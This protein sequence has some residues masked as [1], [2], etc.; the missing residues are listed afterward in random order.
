MDSPL[1]PPEMN[2]APL[3]LCSE[4][5]ETHGKNPDLQDIKIMN[6]CGASWKVCY[7]NLL[8]QPWET[9]EAGR[10]TSGR[11]E[12]NPNKHGRFKH[13]ASMAGAQGVTRKQ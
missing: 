4:P 7:E 11:R 6:V 8:G 1:E 2:S 12:G 13:K 5:G 9:D 3:T 10:G